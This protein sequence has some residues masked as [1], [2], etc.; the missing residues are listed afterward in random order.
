MNG[1]TLTIISLVLS[2]IAVI[3][4]VYAVIAARPVRAWRRQFATGEGLAENVE[5]IIA[6]LATKIKGLE[7]GQEMGSAN[8]T[9]LENLLGH[10]IQHVGLIRY[11]SMADE[12]GNLSFSIALLDARHSGVVITSLHGRQ[13]NRTY[14]KQIT[15]AESETTLSDEERNAIFDALKRARQKQKSK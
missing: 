1:Q 2:G 8:M 12:G 13:Q 14:A 15:E 6:K 11:N 7:S 3:A 4:G 10:S 5:Q 9:R